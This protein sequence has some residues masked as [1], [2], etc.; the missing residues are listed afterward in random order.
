MADTQDATIAISLGPLTIS[1]AGH[2]G[3]AQKISGACVLEQPTF[4]LAAQKPYLGEVGVIH[5]LSSAPT[6]GGGAL[7][8]F[9]GNPNTA[10]TWSLTEGSGSV[11]AL[12]AK[13]NAYG[14]CFAIYTPGGY[15]GTATIQVT[16]GS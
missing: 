3:W 15:T 13:T 6:S 8:Q 2:S 14:R 1:A 16:Y 11:T 10:V 7:Y 4:V 9:S 5:R 12:S